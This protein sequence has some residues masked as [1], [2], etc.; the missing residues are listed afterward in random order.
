MSRHLIAAPLARYHHDGPERLSCL[1]FSSLPC[2]WFLF[3]FPPYKYSGVRSTTEKILRPPFLCQPVQITRGEKGKKKFLSTS[4]N[5]ST[6]TKSA[7]SEQESGLI[8][9]GPNNPIQSANTTTAEHPFL[10]RPGVQGQGWNRSFVAPTISGT[11]PATLH[12]G[13]VFTNATQ[14]GTLEDRTRREGDRET[15][16]AIVGHLSTPLLPSQS[17]ISQSACPADLLCR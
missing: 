5:N 3:L 2:Q 16:F 11:Q 4:T 13:S 17:S 8:H 15:D 9:T 6:Q 1:F 7:G 12:P 14:Q 10:A